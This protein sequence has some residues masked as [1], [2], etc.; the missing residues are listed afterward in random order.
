M[1]AETSSAGLGAVHQAIA[2]EELTVVSVSA[3]PEVDRVDVLAAA[4]E[5]ARGRLAAC[6]LF[7]LQV[8]RGHRGR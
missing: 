1:I 4:H 6:S 7:D 3:A 2:S 8:G 5:V